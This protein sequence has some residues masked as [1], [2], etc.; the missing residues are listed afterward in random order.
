M[1]LRF[2]FFCGIRVDQLFWEILVVE[3]EDITLRQMSESGYPVTKSHIPEG[4]NRQWIRTTF[5]T[6]AVPLIVSD[7]CE[8]GTFP[9]NITL[10]SRN[11]MRSL[12]FGKN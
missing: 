4:R 2:P 7:Y 5:G 6:V 3:D 1:Y 12:C 10:T 11:A 9:F 8:F